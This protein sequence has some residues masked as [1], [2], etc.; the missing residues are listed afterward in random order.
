MNSNF[1]FCSEVGE[2]AAPDTENMQ[3]VHALSIG[4]YEHPKHGKLIFTPDRIRR[5]VDSIKAKVRGIDPDIDY[6]HKLDVAKGMSAAGWVR[7]AE[8][9]P[10]GLWLLVEW[11]K[12]AAQAIAD[13]EYRY[14]S[15]EFVDEWTAPDGNKFTDVV[16]GGGLTNRPF[17]K[18]LEPVNLSELADPDNKE[19]TMEL[20]ELARILG[21][22]EDATEDDV[23]AKLSEL[24]GSAPLDLTKLSITESDGTVVVTHPDVEGEV[25]H[26][27]SISDP[28]PDPSEAEL[29]QLAE[30]NPVI[31]KMLSDNKRMQDDMDELKAQARLSEVTT[32][33][34]DL[35]KEHEAILP[36]VVQQKLAPIMV[37][38]PKQLSDEIAESLKDIIKL[39]VI[40]FGEQVPGKPGGKS[41]DDPVAKYLSEIER[42]KKDNDKLSTREAAAVVKRENPKLHFEYTDAV[43]MGQ[44]A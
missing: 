21:L 1:T 5:F 34:S 12:K 29:A 14:F 11:T 8:E 22:S 42:V 13:K 9:R 30:S 28:D 36:P 3:W 27:L 44:E 37:R 38:L 43:R 16:L 24:A 19:N 33:L 26:T 41:D 2:V 23:K 17:L 35:G 7:D 25:T 20:A 32:Q 10:N 6:D 15:T 40:K 18:N 39:G 31:A 4:E